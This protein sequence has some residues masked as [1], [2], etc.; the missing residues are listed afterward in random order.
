MEEL[1]TQAKTLDHELAEL[2]HSAFLLS[3]GMGLMIHVINGLL[4]SD[5]IS[6]EDLENLY[7]S[8]DYLAKLSTSIVEAI[9]GANARSDELIAVLDNMKGEEPNV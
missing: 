4:G 7:A 8:S 1:I 5:E 2:D 6:D 3:C 9:N